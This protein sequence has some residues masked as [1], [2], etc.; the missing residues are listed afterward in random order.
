AETRLRGEI[1]K[2][3]ADLRDV[4]DALPADRVEWERRLAAK[5]R[6][7]GVHETVWIDDQLQTGGRTEGDWTFVRG[8]PVPAHS[9][10]AYRVQSSDALVQHYV[11]DA[12][13]GT[14]SVKEG[15]VF[16]AWVYLAKGDTPPALMLQLNVGGDWAHRA[17]WGGD[18][19]VF[20]RRA[21]SWPGYRRLGA[22]PETGRWHRLEVDAAAVGLT[23][24][25]VVTGMAFT[26]FGGT[27][28]WDAA[29]VR[30]TRL[31]PAPVLE[32]LRTPQPERTPAQR[33][34]LAGHQAETSP[35]VTRH[36]A[37][38]A[39]LESRLTTLEES[40]PL[41]MY[42]RSAEPREVRILPRGNWLDE[43]GEVVEPASPALMGTLA[44]DGRA[45]RRDLARWL[46]TPVRE[47][48]VGELTARVFVNRIWTL[49]FG[50]G[51]CPSTDD[52]GG[53]GRPPTH[54]E[55]L[56]R[57]AIDFVESGW[58]VKE[59][60]RRLVM[61]RTYRQSSRPSERAAARDPENLLFAR[62]SRY[63]LPA[64]MIRD[65]V[66]VAS[67]LLTDEIGGPSV[68]PPQPAGHYRHLNFPVRE[69]E[70]DAGPE[71]W[72]RGVYVHWQRQFLH[73]MLR[74]FDAPTREDC[75]TQRRVS[76][77]PIA[78][79]ALLNDP[80]FVEASRVF[81]TDLVS[82]AEPDSRATIADAMRR[83]TAR[84][85]S[86]AEV[87]VLLELLDESRRHYA[88]HPDE[89]MQLIEVGSSPRDPS[90]EPATLAA[91]T[92]VTRAILNLHET[93]TRE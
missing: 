41:T 83:A 44:S 62:Q 78:A 36:R 86:D 77:T 51:L 10:D 73:P 50:Q 35:V 84:A 38:I 70:A 13:R 71:Q 2:V 64:E 14:I 61:T 85:P 45:T 5:I 26:Q 60:V 31:A 74:A 72:R 81:A 3:R 48:G 20:G 80:V 9:G 66:L 15:D 39:E 29:G 7:G 27:V 52:F 90:I 21:E 46:V 34:T 12:T 89:A 6:Q 4:I 33:Q 16:F 79:L 32:A 59:L 69:Y 92:Q 76:N 57:L 82:R 88:A 37:S 58:D 30:S 53:Q 25:Q 63:R 47:G 1:E 28:Y 42:T 54:L 55:L 8:G 93:I 49:L 75:T 17:V 67:G 24:G 68:K 56:D 91:W 65:T 40:L 22:L 23:P 11:V 87:R 18:E 19:I 43:S